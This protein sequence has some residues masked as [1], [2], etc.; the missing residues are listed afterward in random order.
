MFAIFYIYIV[1]GL[2]IVNIFILSEWYGIRLGL[3]IFIYAVYAIYPIICILLAVMTKR[4]N[5]FNIPFVGLFAR[6]IEL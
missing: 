3:A 6:E 4:G 1:I 5:K 2:N